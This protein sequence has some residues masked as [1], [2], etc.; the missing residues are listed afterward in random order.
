MPEI[1]MMLRLIYDCKRTRAT[2]VYAAYHH[3]YNLSL[4]ILPDFLDLPCSGLM[5]CRDLPSAPYYDVTQ[6]QLTELI[7]DHGRSSNDFLSA[8]TARA[9]A[10]WHR[11][12]DERAVDNLGFHHGFIREL[13]DRKATRMRLTNLVKDTVRQ[14]YIVIRCH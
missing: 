4:L 6:A 1:F 14:S 7:R 9:I 12:G 8:E 10:T 5:S 11:N 13:S 2:V 3:S